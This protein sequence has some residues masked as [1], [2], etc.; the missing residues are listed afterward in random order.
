MSFRARV[1]SGSGWEAAAGTGPEEKGINNRAMCLP[2][3]GGDKPERVHYRD[4]H[5]QVGGHCLASQSPLAD[6]SSS[7]RRGG[8]MSAGQEVCPKPTVLSYGHEES[9]DQHKGAKER[10]PSPWYVEQMMGEFAKGKARDTWLSDI[11]LFSF[12][13]PFRNANHLLKV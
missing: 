11:D 4:C 5:L 3:S 12:F 6:G 1:L 10:D 2:W 13:Q 8:G 9:S 7:V